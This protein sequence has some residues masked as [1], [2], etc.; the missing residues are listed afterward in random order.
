[1]PIEI[2]APSVAFLA[3]LTL[4]PIQARFVGCREPSRL[5]KCIGHA[6]VVYHSDNE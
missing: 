5:S 1:M 3:S 6:F 4:H 2:D